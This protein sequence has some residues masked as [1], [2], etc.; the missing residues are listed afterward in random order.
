M[1]VKNSQDHFGAVNGGQGKTFFKI[2]CL[3]TGEIMIENQE[4]SFSPGFFQ[5]GFD[6]PLADKRPGM[7]FISSLKA[8]KRGIL[9]CC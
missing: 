1:G 8:R 7:N 5:S 3:G 9:F 2:A 6:K 4:I